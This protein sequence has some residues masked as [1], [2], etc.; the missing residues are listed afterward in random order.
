MLRLETG[1][2]STEAIISRVSECRLE[3]DFD[4]YKGCEASCTRTSAE[5]EH[6]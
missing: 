4:H 3:N 6:L 1:V 2:R 5:R